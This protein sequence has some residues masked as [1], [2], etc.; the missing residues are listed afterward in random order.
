MSKKSAKR[1]AGKENL[2]K[3]MLGLGMTALSAFAGAMGTQAA[4]AF[5]APHPEP[6]VVV[7][8][9]HSGDAPEQF[10]VTLVGKKGFR[11]ELWVTAS[12]QNAGLP[13]AA[14][15]DRASPAVPSIAFR[16]QPTETD[17]HHFFHVDFSHIAEQLKQKPDLHPD[18]VQALSQ[19]TELHITPADQPA[20]PTK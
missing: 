1:A 7:E 8:G 9:A 17:P 6:I 18:A 4:N 20:P 16:F 10:R 11:Q 2:K 19:V 15:S 3:T 14:V 13:K 5:S 12:A